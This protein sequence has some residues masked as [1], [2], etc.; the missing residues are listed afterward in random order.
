MEDEVEASLRQGDVSRSDA[1]ELEDARLR[2]PFTEQLVDLGTVEALA[3][4]RG[5][6]SDVRWRVH[7]SESDFRR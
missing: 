7:F 2:V 5:Q 6:S 1:I 3:Q 4:Q